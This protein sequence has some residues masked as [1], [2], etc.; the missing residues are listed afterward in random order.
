VTPYLRVVR[1]AGYSGPADTHGRLRG[2]RCGTARAGPSARTSM[3]E[4]RRPWRVLARP[5]RPCL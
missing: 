1:L 3:E 4:G 2:P 5:C